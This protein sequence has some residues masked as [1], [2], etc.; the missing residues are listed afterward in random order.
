MHAGKITTSVDF[1]DDCGRLVLFHLEFLN[2]TTLLDSLDVA[3]AD[4]RQCRKRDYDEIPGEV[5]IMNTIPSLKYSSGGDGA[6]VIIPGSRGFVPPPVVIQRSP[7]SYN[8]ASS[9]PQVANLDGYVQSIEQGARPKLP[10]VAGPSSEADY[11]S[12]LS[13]SAFDEFIIEGYEHVTYETSECILLILNRL[14]SEL[15]QVL[16]KYSRQLIQQ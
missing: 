6:V 3:M 9:L 1:R 7:P 11:R 16:E 12:H 4:Q 15:F 8:E 5:I 2:F 14:N 13:S 10:P